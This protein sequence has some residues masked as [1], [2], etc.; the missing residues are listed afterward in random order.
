[1]CSRLASEAGRFTLSVDADPGAVELNYRQAKQD[2]TPNLLPLLLDLTN[3]SPALG[4][5]SAE[6]DSFVERAR[7]DAVMALA[8]IHHL[9]IANN[10]PLPDIGAFFAQLAGWLIVE[11]VPKSDPKVQ[12]LLVTREDIFP[13]YT[14]EGFEAAFSQY[15]EIVRAEHIAESDRRLYLMRRSG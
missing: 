15:F 8:L 1:L 14:P 4:W 7:A 5:R 3:P 9:A 13:M 2:K 10:V 11:F 6:R 12:T